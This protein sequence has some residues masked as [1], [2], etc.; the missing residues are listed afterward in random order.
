MDYSLDARGLVMADRSLTAVDVL[1]GRRL[2]MARMTKGLTQTNLG[3]AVG[4]SFQQI[5]KYETGKNRIGP[6][7]L[8]AMAEVL[9]VAVS[10]FFEGPQFV[11]SAADAEMEAIH[12]ALSTQEGVRIATA[13]SSISDAKLRRSIAD[14]LE[15]IIV[16]K[17]RAAEGRRRR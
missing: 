17:D 7:R 16:S 11:A 10:Y 2:K 6:G 9:G 4:L 15:E 3:Q 14:L 8:H 5:Q 13:L 12:E 1:V